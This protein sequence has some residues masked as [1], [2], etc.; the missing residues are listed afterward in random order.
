[1]Y[2][3]VGIRTVRSGQLPFVHKASTFSKLVSS[4]RE[5]VNFF[6]RVVF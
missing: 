1:M 2:L 3:F 6:F 4:I 5:L